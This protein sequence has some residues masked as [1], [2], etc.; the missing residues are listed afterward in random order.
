MEDFDSKWLPVH[1]SFTYYLY[2]ICMYF[3][4]SALQYF[5]DVF[6]MLYRV[7]PVK[8][9]KLFL[10]PQVIY[11][12]YLIFNFSKINSSVNFSGAKSFIEEIISDISSSWLEII[13]MC[14]VALGLS[15]IMII[16]FRFLAGFIVWIIIWIIALA[17][18]AG[19]L[20]CW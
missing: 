3:S 11:W 7:L 19:P 13:Y 5:G 2:I 10:N 15:I 16:L 6:L 17:C 9:P 1:N 20:V 18:L 8:L 12:S 4:F 14:A